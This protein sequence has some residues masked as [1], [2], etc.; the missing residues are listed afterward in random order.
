MPYTVYTDSEKKR[1]D[2]NWLFL[3]T[4]PMVNDNMHYLQTINSVEIIVID[5]LCV[6]CWYATQITT[7]STKGLICPN[8]KTADHV[9][10]LDTSLLP[11]QRSLLSQDCKVRPYPMTLH[12]GVQRPGLLAHWNNSAGPPSSRAACGISWGLCCNCITTQFLLLPLSV[13]T[14]P[15]VY[16]PKVPHS[17]VVTHKSLPQS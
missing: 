14:P 2:S 15:W 12:C 11:P 6:R 16:L 5:V 3:T 4:K 10:P 9:S 8:V 1:H 13:Y 7:I 17:K